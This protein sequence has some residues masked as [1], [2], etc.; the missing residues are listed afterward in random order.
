MTTKR[1]EELEKTRGRIRA[2]GLVFEGGP[3]GEK[4]ERV[5]TRICQRLAP[6]RLA[7]STADAAILAAAIGRQLDKIDAVERAGAFSRRA[8]R[9]GDIER[10]TAKIVKMRARLVRLERM[11]AG[12]EA[13]DAGFIDP[14]SRVREA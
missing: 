4:A 3:R 11:A 14:F 2:R 12:I 5:L 10:R 6:P 7:V 13:V 8:V 9:P 1:R